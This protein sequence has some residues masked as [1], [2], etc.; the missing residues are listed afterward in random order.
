MQR[1]RR[2]SRSKYPRPCWIQECLCVGLGANRWPRPSPDGNT[3]RAIAG[4]N[5]DRL[6]AF[7]EKQ[8]IELVFTEKIAPA[9]GV[10]YGGRIR[11]SCPDS[12]R[13]KTSPRW[14]MNLAHETPDALHPP[15]DHHQDGTRDGGRS[16]RVRCSARRLVYRT[17][18]ASASISLSIMAT[19]RLLVESLEVVS[20]PPL[21]SLPHWNRPQPQR[22]CPMQNWR[23]WR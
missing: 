6:L 3:F 5:Y 22:R 7:I 16:Y 10:S 23:G 4:E 1:Q 12:R 19:L 8:G 2:T 21:S 15:H 20:R 9:L 18:N 14:C 17:G 13:P 11:Q